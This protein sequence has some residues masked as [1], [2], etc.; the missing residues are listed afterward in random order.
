MKAALYLRVSTGEQTTENQRIELDRIAL[1]RGW[2][3][4]K[5]YQDEGISGAKGRDRRPGFNELCNDATRRKFDVVM[6][7]SVDRISRSL[8]D[9]I[10]F[11]HELHGSGVQLYLHQQALDTTTPSGK[12]MFQ[13]TGAFAEYEREIIRERVRIGI[14][15]AKAEGKR[16]GRKPVDPA[17]APQ[18]VALR[19]KGLSAPKIGVKLGMSARSVWRL[20]KLK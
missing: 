6:A 14:A 10:T 11:M 15:R 4:T 8:I 16:W 19:A 12:L 13:M 1:A 2:Q 18:A 9:L 3:I 5:V 7:W 20:L 17:L